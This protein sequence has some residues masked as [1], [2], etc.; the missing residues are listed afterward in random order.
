MRTATGRNVDHWSV[1]LLSSGG[2]VSWCQ[3]LSPSSK[4]KELFRADLGLDRYF[5]KVVNKG[6]ED[7]NW[8]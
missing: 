6:S 4:H 3:D 2:V 7:V 8:R 5:H 1:S